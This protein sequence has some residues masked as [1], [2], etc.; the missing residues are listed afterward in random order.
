MCSSDLP[1]PGKVIR[2]DTLAQGV[3]LA[4]ALLYEAAIQHLA[5]LPSSVADFGCGCGIVSIMCALARPSWQIQGIDIQENLI[6]L[7]RSNAAACKL[8]IRFHHQD[9][10]EHENV[11][12]LI[13]ANPPWQKKGDGL[14]SPHHSKNLSRVEIRCNMQDLLTSLSMARGEALLLQSLI[15]SGQATDEAGARALVGTRGPQAMA[16]HL[17]GLSADA[18]LGTVRTRLAPRGMATSNPIPDGWVVA[19]DPIAAIRAGRYVKV[20]VLAGNT[21][22][23]TKLFP[24]LLA[25]RPDLGGVSGRL[26]DD[27]ALFAIVSRHGAG[28]ASAT[29][30][31]QWIPPAYLPADKPVTGFDARTAELGRIWFDAIRTDA[32]N[33]LRSQQPNVWFYE[34]D[35]DRLPRPYDVIYGAAHT[36]DLPFVFGNFGPSLYANIIVTRANEPGRLALSEKMMRSIV[37]FARHGDP[38]NDAIGVA[39]RPWPSRL[40]FGGDDERANIRA[41]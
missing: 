2:Q 32:L 20:P 10:R 13:L 31:E 30:I 40:L 1:F 7:A 34:F 28:A 11:Y 3:S 16:E 14:L 17:R 8:D 15:A 4:S 38:N 12:D 33:A 36:F 5:D 6:D 41:R 21:R 25:I 37:A 23:E 9:I 19:S 26:L 27:A 22:D 24:Q 18:L 35:W 39:W 29:T